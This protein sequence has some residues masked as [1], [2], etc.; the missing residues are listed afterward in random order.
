MSPFLVQFRCFCP[1]VCTVMYSCC[2]MIGPALVI[3]LILG[4]STFMYF[5]VFDTVHAVFCFRVC[6]CVVCVP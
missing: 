2:L 1:S 4:H 6:W 3:N 5:P